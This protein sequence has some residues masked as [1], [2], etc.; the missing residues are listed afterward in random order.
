M[1]AIRDIKSTITKINN[2]CNFQGIT[3]FDYLISKHLSVGEFCASMGL[4]TSLL[5]DISLHT[6]ETLLKDAK[7]RIYFNPSMTSLESD[8]ISLYSPNLHINFG[9]LK[10]ILKIIWDETTKDF[11]YKKFA[12]EFMGTR[13]EKENLATI[14]FSSNLTIDPTLAKERI[15]SNKYPL[16]HVELKIR[17]TKH[18]SDGTILDEQAFQIII[19]HDMLYNDLENIFRILYNFNYQLAINILKLYPASMKII[20]NEVAMNNFLNR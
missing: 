1:K 11:Q 4:D 17:Y 8:E 15:L 5:N 12:S 7:T 13:K 18:Q 16:E 19:N 9:F 20:S 14:H 2:V 10:N 6:L 3:I